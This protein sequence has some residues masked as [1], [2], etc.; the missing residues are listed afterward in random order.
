MSSSLNP[1]LAGEEMKVMAQ[2][3]QIESGRTYHITHYK[4]H[5]MVRVTGELLD[6][7]GPPF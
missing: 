3:L 1:C 4:H 7:A 6:N 5:A 2:R